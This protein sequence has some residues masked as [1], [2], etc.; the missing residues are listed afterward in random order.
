MEQREKRIGR[1]PSNNPYSELLHIRITPEMAEWLDRISE[2]RLD[3]P[4]Q[5]AL[6]REALAEYIE[7]FRDSVA[8]K[9]QADA[10]A[11]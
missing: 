4:S 5:A 8:Q 2:Y 10:A 9:H 1:P 7:R 3:Q 11:Q 6:V